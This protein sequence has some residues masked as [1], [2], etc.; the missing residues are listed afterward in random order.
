MIVSLLHVTAASSGVVGSALGR[1]LA[2]MP[3]AAL[4]FFP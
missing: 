2:V 3:A 4:S 1:S